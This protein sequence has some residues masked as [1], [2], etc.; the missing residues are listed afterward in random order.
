MRWVLVAVAASSAVAL[1]AGMWTFVRHRAPVNAQAVAQRDV[2][3]LEG[4]SVVFSAAFATRAGVKTTEVERTALTPSVQVVGTVTFDSKHVAAAG[5]RIRGFVTKVMK[6]EGDKVNKGDALAE[7][8]SAELSHAHAQVAVVA[9]KKSAAERNAKREADLLA[10]SLT[11]AREEERARAELTEQ[12]AMLTAASQHLAAIGGPGAGGF[13]TY[14]VRAPMAG[15][16]VKRSIASGQSV[17]SDLIAFR[18][19]NLD[20]VWIELAVFESEIGSIRP[21]DIAEITPTGGAFGK[22]AGKV[23]YVGD[24][25]DPDARS[26]IVRVKVD[27]QSRQLRPGQSVVAH[28]RPTA[29]SRVVTTI[30]VGAVT[31]VDGRPTVFVAERETQVSIVEVK[32]G[33]SD[34]DR[35]EITEGL[36]VGQRVVSEGVFALKSELFR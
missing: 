25:I 11:T 2:P 22:I 28:I 14:Y 35:Q 1:A 30:P 6:V 33:R 9:A 12:R 34:G 29:L 21:D 3:R 24:V 19:A 13:G 4:R 31:Y 7:I 32:L 27:N 8:Q 23:A 15:T 17:E 18:V 5:T 26:A 36:T 10:S 16:I 20:Q